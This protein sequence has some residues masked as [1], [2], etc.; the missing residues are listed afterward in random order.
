MGATWAV[1]SG[2]EG[3]WRWV[4]VQLAVILVAA[5]L[6]GWLA[7]RLGQPEVIGEFLAGLAL[8]PSLLGWWQ[9][10]WFAAVFRPSGGELVAVT[11]P[12]LAGIAQLGLLFLMFLVGLEADWRRVERGWQ[13]TVTIA[14]AGL[15]VPLVVGV[16]L[17][18]W[19][20]QREGLEAGISGL[21]PAAL[22]VAAAL[23]I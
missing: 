20:A 10:E 3:A 6:G 19:L 14:G 1:A 18:W 9:P 16:P 13:T 8:G 15:V 22:F 12:M 5:R 7:R 4:L 2:G 23:A 17:G 11:E 21:P